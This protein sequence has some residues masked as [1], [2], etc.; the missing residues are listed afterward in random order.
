MYTTLG[1]VQP[2]GRA[3]AR[4]RLARKLGGKSL[5][6]WVVRHVTECQR[7][8]RVVVV[9]GASRGEQAIAELCP[10]DVPVFIGSRGDALGC[11]A[12][13]LSQFPCES[14]VRVYA[15]HPYTDPVLIDRLVRTADEHAGCD[16]ISYC[17]RD[18]RPAILSSV[19]IFGEWCRSEA[20]R[21]AHAE[22]KRPADR[23]HVTRYLFSHPEEFNIRLIPA[24]E[25]LDR[26]DLRLGLGDDEEWEQVQ[27]I[28]EALGSEGV[29][30]RR[31]VAAFDAQAAGRAGGA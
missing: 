28:Y 24:P 6:E 17:F 13:A 23:E 3:E 1:I 22:A 19:G 27:A 12:E 4:G 26:A 18:G 20:L 5:L 30:W 21:R 2:Y 25:E 15:D 7:V 11:V 29:D 14:L 10:P 8:D 16:Y 9:L 31:I